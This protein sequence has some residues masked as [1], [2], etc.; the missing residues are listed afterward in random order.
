[1]KLKLTEPAEEGKTFGPFT[2]AL[3]L[4]AAK[5]AYQCELLGVADASVKKRKL[6]YVK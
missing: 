3:L 1:M 2:R 4:D 6:S 5:I